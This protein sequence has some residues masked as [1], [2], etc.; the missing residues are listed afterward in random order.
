[1]FYFIRRIFELISP[2]KLYALLIAIGLSVT[3]MVQICFPLFYR[4]IFNVAIVHKDVDYL[5]TLLLWAG[6]LFIIM[7]GSY[8]LSGYFMP[9]TSSL[10]IKDLRLKMLDKLQEVNPDYFSKVPVGNTMSRFSNDI[11]AIENA[12]IVGLPVSFNGIFLSLFSVIILFVLEWRLTVVAIVVLP[13]LAAGNHLLGKKANK[14]GYQRR[15]DE[16]SVSSILE[17][18]I[19]AQ[20]TIRAFGAERFWRDKFLIP[21]NKLQHSSTKLGFVT[22]LI[23]QITGRGIDLVV[24]FVIGGGAILAVKEIITVGSLISFFAIVL[25]IAGGVALC[26]FAIPHILKS[27][28]AIR[29]VDELLYEKSTVQQGTNSLA[30]LSSQICINNITFGYSPDQYVINNLSLQISK[31]ETIAFVGPSGSG[32]STILKVLQLLYE[33]QSGS[34]TWDGINIASVSHSSLRSHIGVVSQ[35]T[36]LF[37]TTVENNICLGKTDT[38]QEEVIAAAKMARIHDF[39]INLPEGYKAVICNRDLSGGQR[40]RIAIARALYRNPD[41]LLLDEVTSALD[42]ETEAAIH[43][44]INK[45]KKERT[46]LYV[47]HRLSF[48]EFFDKIF[49]LNEGRLSEQGNHSTLMAQKGLYWQLVQKQRGISINKPARSY[50]IATFYLQTIPLFKNLDESKL[51]I[52]SRNFVLEKYEKGQQIIKQ[53]DRGTRFYIIGRG[54][55]KVL[56]SDGKGNQKMVRKMVDGDFFGEIALVK[57]IPHTATVQAVSDCMVLS[58]VKESFDTLLKDSGELLEKLEKEVNRRIKNDITLE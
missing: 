19:T 16:A 15:E 34:I 33:L 9:K 18:T 7:I 31:G 58:L 3:T 25:N 8:I 30:P 48:V 28:G 46:L 57:T 44:T 43:E 4:E 41:I 6:L 11:S 53:G 47:T 42:A 32:K 49:V 20:M 50:D 37:N 22:F 1:M 51:N 45:L 10:I 14:I 36:Y 35:D 56:V 55:V 39:I 2:Y 21:V 52:L 54:I 40:Q 27:I 38:S 24:L 26:S 29:R 17:E 5:T 13:L 12:L 23:E